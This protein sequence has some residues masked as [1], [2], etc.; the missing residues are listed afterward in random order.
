M[1]LFQNYFSMTKATASVVVTIQ[2]MSLGM[3]M[4]TFSMRIGIRTPCVCT[5]RIMCRILSAVYSVDEIRIDKHLKYSRVHLL[6]FQV[7]I[8]QWVSFSRKIALQDKSHGKMEFIIK[9]C[10]L[11]WDSL[12]IVISIA[13]NM[14]LTLRLLCF[15]CEFYASML[16]LESNGARNMHK[17][18]R[19]RM[20]W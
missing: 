5:M 20:H 6:L 12:R 3:W 2:I 8:I 17:S 1:E 10:W 14:L 7:K 18:E 4:M 19:H 15:I 11:Y 9:V 13:L 16:P